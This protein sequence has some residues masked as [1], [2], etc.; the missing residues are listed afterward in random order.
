[1]RKSYR[2]GLNEVFNLLQTYNTAEVIVSLKTNEIDRDWLKS[3]LELGQFHTSYNE[4]SCKIGYQNELFSKVYEINSFL[5]AIEFLDLERHPYTTEALAILIEFII[6]HDEAIIEKMN[7]P[8]F[9]GESRYLYLG[10]NA[11]EQLGVISRD[12]SEVTLL[13]L[14]DKTST[15]FGKRLLKERLL[16]PIIDKSLLEQRY[17][18]SEKLLPKR[19]V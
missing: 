12:K 6:E 10:N 16:S 15:A 19:V 11:L 3:Y 8:I 4:K 17:D 5:S 2:H 9:L 18:L 14:I 7:R 1:M 13:K